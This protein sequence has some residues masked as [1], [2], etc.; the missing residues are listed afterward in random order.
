MRFSSKFFNDKVTLKKVNGEVVENISA[1]VQKNKIFI[2]DGTLLIEEGDFLFRTMSNGATEKYEVIDRGYYEAFS[3]FEAHY[4]CDVRK[5]TA[6]EKKLPFNKSV[7]NYFN[8]PNSRYNESSTDNS[9]NISLSDANL[10]DEI[11]NELKK[12]D[13]EE[14]EITLL[15]N[16]VDDLEQSMG[17]ENFSTKYTRFIQN[18]GEHV[19]VI[20]PFL[21]ALSQGLIG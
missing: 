13:F 10:F 8:A 16:Q 5:E 17:K 2:S 15:L 20:S 11:K 4:Q 7:N 12:Q 3:G 19:A 14:N 21:P 1:D 6:K 18:L 9:I